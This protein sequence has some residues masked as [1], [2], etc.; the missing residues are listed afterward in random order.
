MYQV[1]GQVRAIRLPAQFLKCPYL[2]IG[3][4]L[5]RRP[6]VI[7]AARSPRTRPFADRMFESRTSAEHAAQKK[8]IKNETITTIYLNVLHHAAVTSG[9]VFAARAPTCR[10]GR[11]FVYFNV[12]E[13]V[14][15]IMGVKAQKIMDMSGGGIEAASQF[16]NKRWKS[17]GDA[18]GSNAVQTRISNGVFFCKIQ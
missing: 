13:V 18:D 8:R 14:N 5:W 16:S 11:R 10:R 9:A 2:R 17:G 7:S 6:H 3:E 15:E 1:L 12:K 4:V